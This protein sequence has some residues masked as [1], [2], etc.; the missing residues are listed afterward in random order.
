MERVDTVNNGNDLLEEVL[1]LLQ[2][3]GADVGNVFGQCRII[4]LD[5]RALNRR[6]EELREDSDGEKKILQECIDLIRE[7]LDDV[8]GSSGTTIH[9]EALADL[10]SS[11]VLGIHPIP[12]G[13]KERDDR[14]IS[15]VK[16]H[17]KFTFSVLLANALPTSLFGAL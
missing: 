11:D 7:D 12:S 15:K 9:R 8:F 13:D 1:E 3:L 14:E 4:M 2:H 6:L 5:F 17:L 10:D 16:L